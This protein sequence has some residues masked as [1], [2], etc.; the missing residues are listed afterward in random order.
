MP[1]EV[2]KSCYFI[3]IVV[4]LIEYNLYPH[5]LHNGLM[6]VLIIIDR[7]LRAKA[8]EKCI[9]KVLFTDILTLVNRVKV[10]NKA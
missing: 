8:T 7:W 1:E 2:H 6:V 5:I 3:S 9:R 10:C 4:S